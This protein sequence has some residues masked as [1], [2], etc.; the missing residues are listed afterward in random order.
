LRVEDLW[1]DIVKLI[2]VRVP[3]VENIVENID[4]LA[5]CVGFLRGVEQL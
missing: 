1:L 3:T 4:Q 2:E 5:Q